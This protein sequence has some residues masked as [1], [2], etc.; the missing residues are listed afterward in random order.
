MEQPRSF[1]LSF[2]LTSHNPDDGQQIVEI[3]RCLGANT[4]RHAN[5]VQR[6]SPGA[7]RSGTRESGPEKLLRPGRA[8]HN[9]CYVS[10]TIQEPRRP[11]L[12]T[13]MFMKNQFAALLTFASLACACAADNLPLAGKWR[14]ELDRPDAGFDRRLFAG[15]LSGSIRLPGSLPE[16]GIGDD[17][18][19]ATPW[20]GGIVD[21]SFFTAPEFAKYREPG[22]IKV[23]FWLQPEKYYVG[24]AWF[25]RD[26][27]VP[28]AWQRKRVVLFLERPHWETR[29]W[30]DERFIGSNNSL[31]TPHQ[32]DLSSLS[33]GK[34]T[35]TIRVDNRRIVDVGENSHCISDHTQ[36]NWN[37][38]VGRIELRATPPVWI[39]DAQV[40]TDTTNKTARVV[41]QVGNA[42]GKPGHGSLAFVKGV[43]S[44]ANP[45]RMLGKPVEW[46]ARGGT[47]DITAGLGADARLWDEFE[48]ALHNFTVVLFANDDAAHAINIDWRELSFGLRDLTTQGTQFLINGRK[49][50]IRGTLECGIF[51]KTGHPPMEE[52]EWRR[53][54]GV[55]KA[56]GLNL[57]RFHSYCPPEAAFRAADELGMYFQIETC[58]ANQSTTLGDGKPVDQWV[59]EETERILRTYGNHPCFLLMPYGNEPGG[60][61]TGSYLAK[62]VTHFKAR[63][64]RQYW[65]SGSG[66]PQLPQNQFH[67]TPD[68]RIQ[69]WGAGLK[70][71]I[72]ANPPETTTDYRAYIAAR[73]VPVISHEIGEWCVYPNFDEMPKYTGYLKPKNFEIFRDFL[74]EHGLGGLS[75]PFLLASGKLQTLCYKEDIESALRT[76]GM[77]GFELLDLH[78]FPGQGTALVGVVD[79]FWDDKGYVTAAEYRRFCNAIVPLARLSKRVFTTGEH[80]VAE[81][82]LANFGPAP[83]TNAVVT[84]KLLGPKGE[85]TRNE[86]WDSEP[87]LKLISQGNAIHLGTVNLD[88]SSVPTPAQYKLAVSV[89]EASSPA[90]HSGCEN[91]W[92]VW[93]YPEAEKLVGSL[94]HADVLVSSRFDDRVQALLRSGGKVLLT[95]PGQQVRNFEAAPVQLGF[96]SIFWN[97]SWTHRQAPTTLGI[98]CDPKHP[99]LEE[100]P[101]SYY[102]NWQWW[103]LIHRA[104]ALRLDHLPPGLQPIVRVIDDWV[105]ARPLGLVIEGKI[106][107]G[108]IVVCGFDLTR[109]ADDPVSRQM[110]ASLMDYM[111]SKRFHPATELTFHQAQSLLVSTSEGL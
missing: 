25:Q 87:A 98:L 92:D 73:N 32:Y 36:G 64:P 76:P 74:A 50:F 110:R 67:V 83:L 15:R 22:R 47:I 90:D 88:L 29:V 56:H 10:V 55:A 77:A 58:W 8:P 80:L 7:K 13:S 28:P 106:G 53:I 75:R 107:S 43:F 24:V 57:L 27:D 21:R 42:T 18:T 69:S 26:V 111:A 4:N 71:R 46:D 40:F 19:L 62:Y 31:A 101:T 70:S 41:V 63:D 20:T 9:L 2:Y 103:Y 105:T 93:V 89:R 102:S 91:D 108:K 35:L 65:T 51:P 85:V 96:S 45:I 23:P 104:G 6:A 30:V 34:H 66:W 97:T 52:Q 49:A 17:I 82:E 1:L 60:E 39:E 54:I 109:D 78:D 86:S 12:L 3:L 72:N 94:S 100:F 95:I 14:F 37:G 33:P 44:P 5:G 68:P 59:Y 79:P 84:W 16:Q 48:P 81:V 38:I 61:R 11:V 99:A